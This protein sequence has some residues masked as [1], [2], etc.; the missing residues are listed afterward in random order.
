MMDLM[1]IDTFSRDY[2]KQIEWTL[3]IA[4]LLHF[5]VCAG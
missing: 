3:I 5:N 2:Q 1:V 4:H